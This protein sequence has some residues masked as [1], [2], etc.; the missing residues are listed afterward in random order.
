[1]P[2]HN[3]HADAMAP[4]S[5]SS[6]GPNCPSG[7]DPWIC[8]EQSRAACESQCNGDCH[9][10]ARSWT[11][12]TSNTEFC[13]SECDIS[14]LK[15]QD[16]WTPFA[17]SW[18][19]SGCYSEKEE[20]YCKVEMASQLA[21]MVLVVT[22]LHFV[23]LFL[24]LYH[25]SIAPLLSLGDAISS[26][27][28]RP[29]PSTRTIPFSHL[30]DVL[31]NRHHPWTHDPNPPSPPPPPPRH[32]KLSAT[33]PSR[34]LAFAFLLTAILG[35]TTAGLA[36]GITRVQRRDPSR[37]PFATG[38]G[39]SVNI[40]TLMPIAGST[41]STGPSA[42]IWRA[43]LLANAGQ[44]LLSLLHCAYNA[45]FTALYLGTEW[46]GYG[47]GGGGGIGGV[48]AKMAGGGEGGK[49]GLRI[50]SV[51]RGAQRASHFLQLPW[52]YGVP[53][54]AASTLL[55]W[56]ASQSVFTVSLVDGGDAGEAG[57][58][59]DSG[60]E[61]ATA[62][63]SDRFFGCGFS[64]L[65]MALLLVALLAL[66]ACL[67]AAALPRFKTG[68][69]V[70]GSCSAAIAAACRPHPRREEAVA[71]S[72][73]SPPS[74]KGLSDSAT[75][76]PEEDISALPLSWGVVEEGAADRGDDG[77]GEVRF[78]AL[79]ADDEAV[80]EPWMRPVSFAAWRER[81]LE[82]LGERNLAGEGDEGGGSVGA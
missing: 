49:K 43:T 64:P 68:M 46:D 29:D 54:S 69:P 63:Q 31:Q 62:E 5:S 57:A 45:L 12:S 53:L 23:F 39:A 44:P 24:S 79:T 32:R 38:I 30:L 28:Q 60:K 21:A 59:D 1:M 50:S 52:R 13:S 7:P 56:L 42:T 11:C 15:Q 16:S 71:G 55:H 70:V 3:L 17:D 74:C 80:V 25:L 27:L 33:T 35:L 34:R 76:C 22:L 14:R 72:C 36:L 18:N 81:A 26:F 66:L 77:G 6:S 8:A 20:E 2:Y 10:D 78:C 9:Y 75:D 19:V 41:G 48:G 40:D 67:L 51:P 82:A 47:G 73:A 65:A 58:R 4:I 61:T 37:N